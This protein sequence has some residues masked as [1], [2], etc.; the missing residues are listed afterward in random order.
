MARIGLY[1]SD[2]QTHSSTTKY[3]TYVS[4]RNQSGSVS[5]GSTLVRRVNGD[6]IIRANQ[7][8]GKFAVNGIVGENIRDDYAKSVNISDTLLPVLPKSSSFTVTSF[9]SL[10]SLAS[11]SLTLKYDVG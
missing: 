3:D 7:K 5:D 4:G 8:W 6:F 9:P 1:N 11:L 10:S 2:T